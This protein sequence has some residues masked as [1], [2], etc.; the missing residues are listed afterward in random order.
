MYNNNQPNE[1]TEQTT[2]QIVYNSNQPNE[3][4]DNKLNRVQHKNNYCEERSF[5]MHK[6]VLTPLFRFDF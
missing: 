1:A 5:Q 3:T 6:G 4:A 2:N